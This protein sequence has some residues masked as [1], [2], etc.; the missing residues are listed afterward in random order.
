M[1]LRKNFMKKKKVINFF[2]KWL[3][4]FTSDDV[5]ANGVLKTIVNKL[6]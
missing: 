4:F 6:F 5:N 1:A 3:I 2:Q